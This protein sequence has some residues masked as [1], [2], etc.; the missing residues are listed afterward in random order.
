MIRTAFLAVVALIALS[1]NAEARPRHHHYHYQAGLV[2]SHPAGCPWRAFCGC[3]A[4]VRVFGHSIR[5]LWLAANWFHFPRAYPAPGMVAVRRHH[6]F[7][8]ESDL[9]GGIWRV[10]DANSGHHLTR[11]HARS[12]AGFAIVNPFG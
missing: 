1:L 2:V 8:L 3:G 11:I 7:V 10:Y 6:V 5:K 4:A 9:G 12:I